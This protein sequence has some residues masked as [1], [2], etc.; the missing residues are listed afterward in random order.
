MAEAVFWGAIAVV[1]YVY[2]GY[3]LLIFL[4]A[5]LR[6]RPVREAPIEPS[7][8]F[9]IAAYNE[10]A[11]IAAKLR[12]T[13]AL[14]YPKDRLEIIVVSDGSSDRTEEIV[15]T[16]FAGRV[17]L[18]ALGG[19]HGK[20][21]AQNRAVEAAQG[22]VL[23]FSDA[24]TVYEPHAV[25]AMM[26]K[27]ADAEVGCA[28]GWVTMG[29]TEGAALHRGRLAYGH[30]EQRLR[31]YESQFSSILGLAGCVY[32]VR[33][34]LYQPL[35]ADVISDVVQGIQ[36]VARGHR[37]VLAE[38][39]EVHEAGESEVITDELER[40]ARIIT[41]GLRGYFYL[42]SFFHPLRHPWFCI[43]L[44][45]HRLLRWA[46]PIFLLVALAANL[47][48]LDRPVYRA[49]FVAQ[50]GL[51]VVAAVAYVLDRRR[52]RIPGL[53]IPLYFCVVN[54]APLLALR[55]LLRGERKVVWE[56]GR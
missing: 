6:P 56:T 17:T 41:R 21:I 7:V 52:V 19:R 44:L 38:D 48:L 3:P 18:L 24:T 49:L 50:V 45:S 53:S 1:I 39:A 12:N 16:Q 54:V 13:L 31:R 9:I 42:R 43:Q 10:E 32:A 8:S 26:R 51:Y 25:R 22:D 5:Q 55:A 36:V 14:D 34:E 46:V 40:R 28:T 30:Y 4:L 33:R 47:F 29:V 15:R 37:A 23:F 11:S 27:F 2:F 35:A 20:T